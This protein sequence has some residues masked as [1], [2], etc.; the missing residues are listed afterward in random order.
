[1]ATPLRVNWEL[2]EVVALTVIENGLAPAL[3]TMPFASVLGWETETLVVLDV[4][5]VAMSEA[6]LGTVGGV[7][8][9]AV[10]QS[11]ETGFVF[12]VALSANVP[13]PDK[14]NAARAP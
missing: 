4:A 13:F 6:P 7:K 3:N 10:F 2:V 8:L 1:M 14:R 12:H 5:N 11:P 9:L